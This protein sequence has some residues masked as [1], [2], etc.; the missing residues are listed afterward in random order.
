LS[1]SCQLVRG[2]GILSAV[3]QVG[4]L[5]F[6]VVLSLVSLPGQNIERSFLHNDARLLYAQ[7]SHE[8]RLS[9]YLP[10]P[11]SFSD[12]VSDEQAFF[13]FQR[14]FQRYVTLEFIPDPQIFHPEAGAPLIVKARWFLT[15]A[16]NNSRYA[17]RIYFML[18]PETPVRTP[19]PS[20]QPLPFPWR[21]IEIKAEKI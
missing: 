9:V 20:G 15:D 7:L 18:Q 16:S 13:L 11:L 21:I 8:T 19:R 17:L 1:P 3:L 10:E 6:S 5:V 2:Y 12:Q 14:I 4:A